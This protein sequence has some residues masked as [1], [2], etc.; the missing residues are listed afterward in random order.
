MVPAVYHTGVPPRLITWVSA[1]C[2]F[3][4]VSL[5]VDIWVDVLLEARV[6]PGCLESA[7][8]GRLLNGRLAGRLIG[9]AGQRLKFE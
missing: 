8:C 1:Y 3:P 6:R 5:P 4:G 2:R 7:C 9:K